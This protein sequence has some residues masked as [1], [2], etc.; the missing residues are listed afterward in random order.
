MEL[1]EE[2][3]G[4]SGHDALDVAL[5]VGEHVVDAPELRA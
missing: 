1:D 5:R 3:V 2:H 4:S